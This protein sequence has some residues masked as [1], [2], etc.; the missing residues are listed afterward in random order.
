MNAPDRPDLD[1][2]RQMLL[3]RQQELR[4]E[5][6]AA[7]AEAPDADAGD[8]A[9]VGDQKDQAAAW[10]Q[11]EVSDA[12][13]QR[14]LDE[15][16]QVEHALHRLAEGDYGDCTDCGAAIPLA[17]LRVQPA[18]LRCAACQSAAERRH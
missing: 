15:L 7:R 13:M 3:H 18:A 2:L 4:A 9:E 1:A 12:E 6:S 16:A 8:G 10:Q 17:R 11:A 14:D 5:V